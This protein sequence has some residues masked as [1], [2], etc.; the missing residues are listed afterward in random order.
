MDL[1]ILE[2]ASQPNGKRMD[3]VTKYGW[4]IV[5]GQ[6]EFAL[7]EKTRL[8]VDASYQR[9]KQTKE[10]L[11]I[12]SEWSW[13]ACGALIVA[14]R[15]GELWL[16][17]GQQR[18]AAALRRSDIKKLPC[19][20]F[21]TESVA[22]EADA[23]SRVNTHRRPVSAIDRYRA[24]LTAGYETELFVSELLASLGIELTNSAAKPGQLKAIS[25]VVQMAK[26]NREGCAR[27]LT[28]TAMLCNESDSYVKDVL[29]KAFWYIDRN[30]THRVDD[31]RFEQRAFAV[32]A[33][34]LEHEATR[35][36]VLV[37]SAGPAVLAA[38]VLV[39]MNKGLRSKFTLKSGE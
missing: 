34:V 9:D 14:A 20:V 17:D 36:A 13:T 21:D 11:K 5:D 8:K 37:G 3:K 1:Q 12:A 28:L 38:G 33:S 24:G 15:D 10:V 31:G 25:S 32:G 19:L 39:A 23:F 27:V 2:T 18:H 35:K 22:Q 6:G 29:L 16:V 30:S 26:V 4:T 7:I